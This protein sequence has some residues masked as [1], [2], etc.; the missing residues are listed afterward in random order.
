MC[1]SESRASSGIDVTVLDLLTRLSLDA[2]SLPCFLLATTCCACQLRGEGKGIEREIER[3][4]EDAGEW[5]GFCGRV[6]QPLYTLYD[7]QRTLESHFESVEKDLYSSQK[8]RLF[9]V[10]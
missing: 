1:R 10:R 3:G 8:M 5:N 6:V 9:I 2:F 4:R 7:D